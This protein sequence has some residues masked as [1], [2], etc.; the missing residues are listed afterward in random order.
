M[1]VLQLPSARQAPLM[2]PPERYRTAAWI[3]EVVFYGDFTAEWVLKHCPRE[4][5]SRKCV[6]F[7][8]SRVRRWAADRHRAGA[9]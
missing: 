8:E 5:L 7:F 1:T 3:A 2:A 9:A 6:R 4:Q